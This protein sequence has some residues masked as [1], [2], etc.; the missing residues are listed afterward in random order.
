[1]ERLSIVSFLANGHSF[2]LYAYDQI[3]NLPEG[4]TLLPADNILPSSRIFRYRESDSYAGFANLFRYKLLLDRGGWWTDLDTICLQP[5]DFPSDFVF[6]S[7]IDRGA[8]VVDAAAIKAPAGSALA[9]YAFRVSDAK[10]TEKLNWGE[11]GPRLLGEA[12]E[13]FQL[14]Q[15]VQRSSAFCPIAWPDWELA[16]LPG[17]DLRLGPESFAG[18][19]WDVFWRRNGRDKDAVYPPDCLFEVLK[20]RYL[21]SDKLE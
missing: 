13:R 19:L 10:I 5:F 4:V 11:T 1:M 6:S 8:E 18:H 9:E 14:Q 20:S 7:E 17:R 21:G 12:V 16:L 2:H 15:H 3:E